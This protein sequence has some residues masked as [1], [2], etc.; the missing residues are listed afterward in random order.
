M[1]ALIKQLLR[2]GLTGPLEYRIEHMGYHHG[3]D[4]Y[5]LGVYLN[6]DILGM[7]QYTIYDGELTVRDIIVLPKHRRQGI[8]S[9]MMQYIKQQHPDAKYVPSMMTDLG[10][11]FKHKHHDD[12][13]N[14]MEDNEEFEIPDYAVIEITIPMAYMDPKYYYQAVPINQLDSDRIYI[15]K[16]SAGGKSIST[17]SVRVLK[18]FKY[19]EKD[20]MEAYLNQL[21]NNEL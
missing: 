5:E 13:H 21:R 4:D 20:E 2:E 16:G 9:K 3:Q 18:T 14:M 15:W 12:L 17:K 8:G 11:K 1:K 6:D 19:N 7:V 10:V